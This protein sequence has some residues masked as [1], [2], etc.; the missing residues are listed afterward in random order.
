MYA[1]QAYKSM[2]CYTFRELRNI[3]F[4]QI[5]FP[6]ESSNGVMFKMNPLD[7]NIPGTFEGV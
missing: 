1:N 7:N 6:V 4:D 3:R 5:L 2:T